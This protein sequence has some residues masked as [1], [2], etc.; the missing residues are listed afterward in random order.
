MSRAKSELGSWGE[1]AA[2][3][4]MVRRG[5]RLLA[6]NYRARVG[7]IDLVFEEQRRGLELVFVEV[8]IRTSTS[9][10]SGAES[11][12]WRKRKRLE[13]TARRFLV[14]Y[15]GG[16]RSVRFD[17]LDWDGKQWTHWENAW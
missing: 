15:R 3:D 13:K 11:V 16:A 9:W 12:D 10:V 7:E 2:C 8:R 4:W 6:R 14:D 1:N 17:I 5:A